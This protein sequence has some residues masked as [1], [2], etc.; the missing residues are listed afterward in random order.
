MLLMC[1]FLVV[2]LVCQ[3]SASNGCVRGD[4]WHG[5]PCHVI[6]NETDYCYTFPCIE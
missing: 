6:G 4:E 2:F 1:F 5:L 3:L